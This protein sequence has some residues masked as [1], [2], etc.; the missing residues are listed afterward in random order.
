MPTIAIVGRKNVGKSSIF[1]RLIGKRVS[2]VH[3]EPGIT[4]DRLYGEVLWQ[5][6]IFN[7]IDTGGFFPDEDDILA[8]KI[9]RQIEMA[10]KEANLIYF[11]VDAKSGL[12]PADELIC[13]NLR[14]LNKEIFLLVNKVDNQKDSLK[15]YEFSKLGITRTFAVSAEA[16]KGFGEVLD[17]TAKILH[18]VKVVKEEKIIKILILGRPN[19]GKSTLL[20][21]ILNQER[22]VVD[23][24]PGTTRDLVSARFEYKDKKFEIIDTWGMKRRASIKNPI[25]FY[26]M[27]RVMRVID[28]IDIAVIIFDVFEGVVNEDLHI[29]ALV[30]SKAKGMV[31]APN[32]IDLLK[33]SALSRVILSTRNSFDFID[34]VPVI[35]ISAKR[36]I[37]IEHLLNTILMVY[38]ESGKIANKKTLKTIVTNLKPPPRGAVLKIVQSNKRPPI[39]QVNITASIKENYIKYLRH[40]LRNYFGFQGVPILIKTKVVK[41][42]S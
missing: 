21:T 22:A 36:G 5:G 37:G 18:D 34:F 40:T 38:E 31:I 8:N 23:D 17:E 6:K 15:V 1:N 16:G 24:T 42:G 35:P 19:A 30:L 25:E 41:K 27:M 13:N 32:K 28:E 11:V 3:S 39:F 7:I 4:R 2:I 10:L 12:L 33:K 14:P 20:N 9:T 26:S 29:A